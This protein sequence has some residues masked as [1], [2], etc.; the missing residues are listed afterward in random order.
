M[1]YE[2]LVNAAMSIIINAGDARLHVT[3]ALNAISENHYEVAT[4]KLKQAQEKI[5]AAHKIQTDIIQ[6]EARGE[7]LEYSFL[8]SHAQDTLMTIN[9]EL[10]LAK[11]LCKVFKSFEKRIAKLEKGED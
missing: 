7:E 8:F 9:S 5:T 1:E 6:G 10:N 11:Q 3:E 4:E 2:K